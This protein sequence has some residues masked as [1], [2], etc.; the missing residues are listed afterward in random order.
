[1]FILAGTPS[2]DLRML[3]FVKSTSASGMFLEASPDSPLLLGAS[4]ALGGVGPTK[5]VESASV[6]QSLTRLIALF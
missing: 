4:F 2:G 6:R 1:M 3:R 5:I